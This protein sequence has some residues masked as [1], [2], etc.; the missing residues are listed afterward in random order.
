MARADTIKNVTLCEIRHFN[1]HL[2]T[3]FT[4]YMKHYLNA[5][6]SFHENVR[7]PHTHTNKH[8]LYIYI[9]IYICVC[10]C[11]RARARVYVCVGVYIYIYIY[12]G[13]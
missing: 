2:R 7:F 4:A 9:Y 11:V 1:Q 10:V 3:D 8:I 6:I 13:R 12:I 5:Q